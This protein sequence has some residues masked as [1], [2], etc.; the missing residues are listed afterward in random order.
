MGRR[1]ARR[2]GVDGMCRSSV[3]EEMGLGVGEE[4]GGILMSTAQLSVAV[5]AVEM[6][7]DCV[8]EIALHFVC[9]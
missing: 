8:S 5:Q 4:I 6:K 3:G 1:W 9:M 7:G 2:W